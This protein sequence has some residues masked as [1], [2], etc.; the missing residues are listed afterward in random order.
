MRAYDK[1]ALLG[2]IGRL[3]NNGVFCQFLV[4]INSFRTS[5]SRKKSLRQPHKINIARL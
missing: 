5:G 4:P 2:K 1:V 3:P